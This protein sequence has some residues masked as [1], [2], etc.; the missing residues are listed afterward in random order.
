MI[1]EITHTETNENT[2]NKFIDG[3]IKIVHDGEVVKVTVEGENKKKFTYCD[4]IEKMMIF[5][6]LAS[7]TMRAFKKKYDEVNEKDVDDDYD[8]Y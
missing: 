5:F 3:R 7:S 1:S 8:S 6:E 2:S 4:N